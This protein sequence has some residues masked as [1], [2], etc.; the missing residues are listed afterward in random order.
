M[1]NKKETIY[2]LQWLAKESDFTETQILENMKPENQKWGEVNYYKSAKDFVDENYNAQEY[3]L[4]DL[5]LW[6]Q[7]ILN[8]DHDFWSNINVKWE[9]IVYLLNKYTIEFSKYPIKNWKIVKET[10]K[11]KEIKF[12]K[13]LKI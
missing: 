12:I 13:N 10:K 1:Q 8:P 2:F 6:E 7:S 5:F 4:S 3:W 9:G 11:D